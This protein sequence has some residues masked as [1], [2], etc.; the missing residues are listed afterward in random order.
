MD[1]MIHGPSLLY[2]VAGS[3]LDL[4]WGNTYGEFGNVV[5]TRTDGSDWPPLSN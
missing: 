5:I 4:S 2:S 3:D 1:T